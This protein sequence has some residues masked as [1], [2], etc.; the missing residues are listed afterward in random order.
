MPWMVELRTNTGVVITRKLP[1]FVTAMQ[2]ITQ[3]YLVKIDAMSD[4]QLDKS[5]VINI[6]LRRIK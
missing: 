6:E 5:T 2:D 3:A 4:A 1:T